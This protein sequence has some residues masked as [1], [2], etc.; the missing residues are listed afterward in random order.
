MNSS[1]VFSTHSLST[2]HISKYDYLYSLNN[3]HSLPIKKINIHQKSPIFHT[4]FKLNVAS[5]SSN[6]IEEDE[7]DTGEY[8]VQTLPP[9]VKR[10]S[11]RMKNMLELRPKTEVTPKRA[12]EIIRECLSVKFDETIE[13]HAKMNLDPR[14]ANQQLR[15]TGSFK[16]NSQPIIKKT[17][18]KLIVNLPK[19]TG[20]SLKVA[21]LCKEGLE[22]EAKDAGADF[23]GG[24]S[25]IQQIT[26]GISLINLIFN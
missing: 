17:I 2:K 20:K 3:T 24:E 25:L 7:E 18:Y 22:Q 8:I 1:F 5:T 6:P 23:V 10:K 9:R 16:F 15:S 19:G 13:L 26:E 14:Y 21:V 11:K 4:S 12:L